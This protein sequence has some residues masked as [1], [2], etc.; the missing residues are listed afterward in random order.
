MVFTE[1]R[2]PKTM[3]SGP[4]GQH[5]EPQRLEYQASLVFS[6]QEV[7]FAFSKLNVELVFPLP[8]YGL[9]FH[10]THIGIGNVGIDI[11]IYDVTCLVEGSATF[12]MRSF[13]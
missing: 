1:G 2:H 8:H 3:Y 5:W 10:G 6:V 7:T 9:L 4:I 12:P 13:S 11:S